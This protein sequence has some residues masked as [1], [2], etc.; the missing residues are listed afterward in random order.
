MIPRIHCVTTMVT[1][2]SLKFFRL[3]HPLSC[4]SPSWF[5]TCCNA[6]RA[7][8]MT[9]EGE[10]AVDW[11]VED[12]LAAHDAHGKRNGAVDQAALSEGV[13]NSPP[14]TEVEDDAISLG[15]EDDDMEALM[16]YREGMDV[17]PLKPIVG[18]G[19]RGA[20][21]VTQASP[22][23]ATRSSSEVKGVD[24][25]TRGTISSPRSSSSKPAANTRLPVP[26]VGVGLPARPNFE[27]SQRVR[28]LN[29][30]ARRPWT[31][32]SRNSNTNGIEIV[33]EIARETGTTT[34]LAIWTKTRH[35]G[36]PGNM[37][38][39][40]IA[41]ILAKLMQPHPKRTLTILKQ[42]KFLLAG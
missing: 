3:S 38:A 2:L 21:A 8:T 4:L 30:S 27:S 6:K 32:Y 28:T 31:M 35:L 15:E 24:S 14:R 23:G 34:A 40:Q 10:E 22:N 13:R 16:T 18:S 36:D 37:A 19:A 29:H 5:T 26:P 25:G 39:L 9:I 33:T 7:K 42:P 20:V 17:E 11:G 1:F 12:D 41:T